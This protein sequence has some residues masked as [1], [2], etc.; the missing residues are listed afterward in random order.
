MQDPGPVRGAPDRREGMVRGDLGFQV[1]RR[2][3]FPAGRP[4]EMSESL[5]DQGAVPAG[6]ILMFEQDQIARLVGAGLET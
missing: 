2:D 3:G 5:L 6:P 1:I 4:L